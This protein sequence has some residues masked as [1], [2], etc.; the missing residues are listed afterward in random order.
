MVQNVFNLYKDSQHLHAL[1]T[2]GGEAHNHSELKQLQRT[3]AS[4]ILLTTMIFDGFINKYKVIQTM[5]II[6]SC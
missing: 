5:T 4:R 6:N 1:L 3:I 2:P